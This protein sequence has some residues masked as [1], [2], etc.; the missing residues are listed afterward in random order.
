MSHYLKNRQIKYKVRLVTLDKLVA[1][2]MSKEGYADFTVS[3][4]E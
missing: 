4:V 1:K 3:K 2:V